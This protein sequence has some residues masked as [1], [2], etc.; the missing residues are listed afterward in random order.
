[1]S[2][3]SVTSYLATALQS[4]FF[5]GGLALGGLGLLAATLR[6]LYALVARLVHR[7]VW[8]SLV[9]DNRSPAYRHFCLW[10]EHTGV[11]DHT[12]QLRLTD[13]SWAEGTK[14]YAPA[15]GS[16][17]FVYQG[18]LCRLDR[19]INEKAKVGGSYE[20]RPMEVLEITVLFGRVQ[21]LLGWIAKGRDLA[22][23]RDRIGPSLHVLKGDWWDEVGEVPRRA[24]DTVL[25]DDDRVDKL[26]E[27]LRWFHSAQ[28]WYADRGVPWRRG[29]LLYGPPGTGKSSLIRALASELSLD[30]ATMDLGRI[31]LSD[32][33]LR[34]AMISAPART[35]LAIEDIDAV[36]A[37]RETGEKR[38][39]ISFSGLLN[40][41][42]GVAAQEGRALIMTTNHKERLDP[43]LIRPGR[44]DMHLELGHVRAKTARLLF[45]RFFPGEAE[46][47]QQFQSRLDASLHSPA[48][49]QAWLLANSA[50][51]ELAAQALDLR[52]AAAPI[53]AE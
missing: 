50:N 53:A 42:D 1:M 45:E 9:L 51:P 46:L 22:E 12:R 10:M 17:W 13:D 5:A 31:G 38:A 41:I 8:V 34:D 28:A 15:P 30:I 33:D 35:L 16:H 3:D 37:Q 6:T 47:A 29:Y 7:R 25:T 39:T 52:P 48:A 36:F 11:L 27:D 4:D 40:A 49:I 26:L 32:D 19:E 2:W 24:I 20:Q 14:G 21:T 23:S 44:A 43:A 18:H